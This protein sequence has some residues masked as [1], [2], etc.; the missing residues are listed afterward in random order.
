LGDVK[1]DDEESIS[2]EADLEAVEE[3][4]VSP[5]PVNR[6][7]SGFDLSGSLGNL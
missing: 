2:D 7:A 3:L 5:G 6:T 4:P 1:D